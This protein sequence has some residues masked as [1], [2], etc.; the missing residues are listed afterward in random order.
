MSDI[1]QRAEQEI[2]IGISTKTIINKLPEEGDISPTEKQML[3]TV[4]HTFYSET[5]S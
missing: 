1:N 2:F 4:V 3:Y 5:F